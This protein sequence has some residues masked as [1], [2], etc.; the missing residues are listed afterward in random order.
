MTIPQLIS[1]IVLSSGIIFIISCGSPE[2]SREETLY[3]AYCAMCHVAP[4]I[5][6]LPRHLWKDKILPEMGARMGIRENGY[7]P[8]AGLSFKEMEAVMQSRIYPQTPIIPQDDWQMLKT[9]ILGLAPDSLRPH[10][11]S[12][13]SALTQFNVT[14]VTLD[15]QPGTYITFLEYDKGRSL[16]SYGDIR[17]SLLSYDFAEEEASPIGR[18][19]SAITAY[20]DLDSIA[21]VTA[22]GNLN[23]SD[24]KSGR[25]FSIKDKDT[26]P[27][28]PIL[29]RP[30]NNLVH[31]FNKDGTPELVVSE[32]GHLQGALSILIDSDTAGY[33]RKTLLDQPG[34]IRVLAKDM[35]G[36]GKDDIIAQTSQGDESITILYQEEGLNFRPEKVIRLSPVYGSS[37]FE[38]IDYDGDGDD[39]IVLVHGDNADKTYV[40]KPY[41]GMRI[42][43][44]DGNGKFAERY[45]YAMDG[46]TRIVAD[47][48]DQ[49]GDYDFA[50]LSTFPDYINKPTYSFV[51]LENHDTKSFDFEAFT[52]EEANLGRWFLMDSGDI[53]EDGDIDIILSAFSYHF[54]PVPEEQIN[55]WNE[56][57][58]DLLVLENKLINP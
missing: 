20:T 26:Q 48:F 38:L 29:H 52:F 6:D 46:V 2:V 36:D 31:D 55:Y 9:Y 18:F 43:L 47:D 41:H 35:N 19:P 30:V 40:M 14:P 10:A 11:P 33:V 56:Q 27:V 58:L 15:D 4:S 57:N 3:N 50:L 39:D 53:D 25:I 24:Q 1:K 51:Y 54:I 42:Y 32:F 5:D 45:F 49:D 13:S 17:G 7:N 23:P 44:N 28:E 16:L 34:T 12:P 22:V 37:W 21:Y 8:M